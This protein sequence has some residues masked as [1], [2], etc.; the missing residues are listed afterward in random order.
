MQDNSMTMTTTGSG[1]GQ[2]L[3]QGAVPPTNALDGVMKPGMGNYVSKPPAKRKDQYG[4]Y[5]VKTPKHLLNLED[6][7]VTVLTTGEN[8]HPDE[9]KIIEHY[10]RQKAAQLAGTYNSLEDPPVVLRDLLPNM[11]VVVNRTF[12]RHEIT[13]GGLDVIKQYVKSLSQS[14]DFDIV[15]HQ[16][17]EVLVLPLHQNVP[18]QYRDPVMNAQMQANYKRSDDDRQRILTQIVEQ[19]KKGRQQLEGEATDAKE[20]KRAERQRDNDRKKRYK[21]YAQLNYTQKQIDEEESRFEVAAQKID[22][23]LA[24]QQQQRRLESAFTSGND[25]N[26]VQPATETMPDNATGTETGEAT[27]VATETIVNEED[28]AWAAVHSE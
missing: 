6:N 11:F 3:S 22:D 13:L 24:E 2:S 16:C 18:M 23:Q 8:R 4:K 17:G 21:M 25:G 1:G 5:D 7:Y 28:E 27:S 9:M 20:E 10:A 12:T 26:N 14:V 15:P 19:Q